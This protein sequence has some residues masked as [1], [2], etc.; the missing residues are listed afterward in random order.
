MNLQ[1]QIKA[2][3]IAAMKAK[4]GPKVTT[5]K[6]L[7]AL[8]TTE[9]VKPNR[10]DRENLTDDEVLALI[11]RG[12][13]QRKDSIQQ[14]EDGGRPELAA[15]EQM[16][17]ACLEV[18]L[19]ETMNDEQIAKIASA[20]KAELGIDDKSKMGILVGAVM[21]ETKG[22]ADGGDVSRVVSSLFD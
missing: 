12:V 22:Q 8:F 10:E 4:D 19:P 11:K 3:M 9:L 7:V 15:A 16:E 5:L 17:L 18:Y 20:K 1:Q 6:S 13:K 14:F 2:D 21:K